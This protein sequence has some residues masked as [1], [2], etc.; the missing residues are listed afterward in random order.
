MKRTRSRLAPF[1]RRIDVSVD[2]G[3]GQFRLA[4][5]IDSMVRRATAVRRVADG[6][7]D[8]AVGL[9]RHRA[10]PIDDQLVRHKAV[11]N[12]SP[13]PEKIGPPLLSPPSIATK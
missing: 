11:V 13:E 8:D 9:A 4:A 10:Q 7:G 6:V 12:L 2:P 5:E 3:S 1:A